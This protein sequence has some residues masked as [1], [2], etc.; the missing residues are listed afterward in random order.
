MHTGLTGVLPEYRR[1]R[2]ALALKQRALAWA[3]EQGVK[4]VRTS[5]DST[6]LRMLSINERL[7]FVKEPAWIHLVR[8]V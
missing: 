1:R 6:N 8:H 5:N 2:I 3:R 7:G 4:L